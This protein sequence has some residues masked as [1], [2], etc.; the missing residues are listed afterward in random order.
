MGWDGMGWDGMGWDGEPASPAMAPGPRLG[1]AFL[2]R[3]R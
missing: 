1:K 3:V 2:E